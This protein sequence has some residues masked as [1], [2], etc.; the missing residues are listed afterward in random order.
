[1]IKRD[2]VHFNQTSITSKWCCWWL[3]RCYLKHWL[4]IANKGKCLWPIGVCVFACNLLGL[5]LMWL[6]SP[7]KTMFR[8]QRTLITSGCNSQG[9]PNRIEQQHSK[10]FSTESSRRSSRNYISFQ[11]LEVDSTCQRCGMVGGLNTNE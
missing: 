7:C 2:Q 1:M 3:D 5:L 6:K 10:L 8:T 4:H 11:D 9:V